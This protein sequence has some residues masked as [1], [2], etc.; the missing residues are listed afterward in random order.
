M[1]RLAIP[2]ILL[3]AL[4]W[5]GAIISSG[6]FQS[7]LLGVAVILSIIALPT[8]WTV[9]T[10]Y[11]NKWEVEGRKGLVNLVRTIPSLVLL[12]LAILLLIVGGMEKDRAGLLVS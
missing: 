5:I 3:T 1:N 2:F 4:I 8:A 9:I 6:I 12:I 11:S 10:T 7:I